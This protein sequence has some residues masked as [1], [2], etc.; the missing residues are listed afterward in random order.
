MVAAGNAQHRGAR[1]A[2]E[3]AFGFSDLGDA[4]VGRLGALCVVCDGM[5]G[6]RGGSE[7]SAAATAAFLDAFRASQPDEPAP[8]VLGRALDAANAVVVAIG[9]HADTED[10]GTTL[11]AALV[12]DAS[13][14]W[15]GVGDTRIALLRDG[16]LFQVTLDHTYRIELL[17]RAA[18]GDGRREDALSDRQGDRLTSSLGTLPVARVDRSHRGLPLR[19][20]DRVLVMTDGVYRALQPGEIAALMTGDPHAACEAVIAAVL[21]RGLPNQ[22]NATIVA[23]GAPAG[24]AHATGA[25]AGATDARAG[26]SPG[27]PRDAEPTPTGVAD[28]AARRTQEAARQRRMRL[29][30]GALALALVAALGVWLGGRGAD[31]APAP[32]APPAPPAGPAGPARPPPPAASEVPVPE[33]GGAPHPGDVRSRDLPPRGGVTPADRVG[34][35]QRSGDRKAGAP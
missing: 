11:A 22:D 5:G 31:D 29:G 9:R 8:S 20:G 17:R 19:P 18:A 6:H 14:H 34:S 4:A 25:G 15:V 13:L 26:A 16:G 24:R 2:Q 12:R 3:D 30:A 23:I 27:G 21:D 32:P 28:D 35:T 33:A 7:A 1:E 10:A